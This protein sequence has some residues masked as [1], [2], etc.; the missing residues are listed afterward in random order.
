MGGP[1]DKDLVPWDEY[2][3]V[4]FARRF[5]WTPEQ[6]DALPLKVEGWIWPIMSAL[7]D[8]EEKRAEQQAA[9]AER[10]SKKFGRRRR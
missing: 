6:V 10:K 4:A 9:D 1:Y 8:L 2:R 5:N 3:Y 7:D